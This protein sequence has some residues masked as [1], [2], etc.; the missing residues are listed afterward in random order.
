MCVHVRVHVCLCACAC[1]CVR[2]FIYIYTHAHTHTSPLT[3]AAMRITNGSLTFD[4]NGT[5][6]NIGFSLLMWICDCISQKSAAE[7]LYM[8]NLAAS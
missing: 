6:I 3:A 2:V 5:A 4:R 7:S 1:V 8:V